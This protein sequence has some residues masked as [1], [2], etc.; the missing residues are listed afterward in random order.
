MTNN[1][2]TNASIAE[3]DYCAITNSESYVTVDQFSYDVSTESEHFT[4]S[5]LYSHNCRSLLSV[6]KTRNG[7]NNLA[8]A[9]N[10]D[11]K[12]KYYGRLTLR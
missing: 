10:Y 12:P 3:S 4:V 9:K 6:D 11:G 5:G 7:W 2:I 8:R 1:V